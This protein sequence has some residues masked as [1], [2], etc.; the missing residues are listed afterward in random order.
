[1]LVSAMKAC[2]SQQLPHN[3]LIVLLDLCAPTNF[4]ISSLKNLFAHRLAFSALTVHVNTVCIGN[5]DHGPT[6]PIAIVRLDC[7]AEG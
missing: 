1:M 5:L 3:I 4:L 2:R 7:Y 6:R